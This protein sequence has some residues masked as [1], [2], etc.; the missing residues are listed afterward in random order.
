[1]KVATARASAGSLI[2]R[3]AVLLALLGLMFLVPAIVSDPS[4]RQVMPWF[5]MLMLLQ[6]AP[7]L[8]ARRQDLFAPPVIGGIRSL[9]ST[10]GT[11][12][13]F[14]LADE[15]R[16]DMLELTDP[17]AVAR[18][19][20]RAVV[21]SV[22]GLAAQYVGYYGRF[23]VT[24]AGAF[25]RVAGIRWSR[26]TL[27][28][29]CAGPALAFLISYTVF[30]LRVGV[31]L[32]DVTQLA[33]GK[34]VWRDNPDLSWMSRGV[35]IGFLPL[36]FFAAHRARDP[37]R[38]ALLA[39][40]LAALACGFLVTRLGQRGPFF[41]AL[42]AGIIIIHYLR[43][44]V[45]VWAFVL[46][47]LLG[48]TVSNLLIEYRVADPDEMPG[49]ASSVATNPVQ[50]L[51]AHENERQRFATLALVI[52]SFPDKVPYLAGESWLSLLVAP[53]PRWIWPEKNQFFP[54]QDNRIVYQLSGVPAP[55][56]FLG[57]LYANLSWIGVVVGMFMMGVF[58]RAL[59]EW[60][61]RHPG[62]P[63]VALLYGLILI[64]FEPTFL[65]LS[66]MLQY[67]FP[68]WLMIAALALLGRE[69]RGR[70]GHL[71]S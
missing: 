65:G 10:L 44:R 42:L 46:V 51:A 5:A 22:I 37:G 21:A 23:G 68:A 55:T 20:T 49:G 66:A 27:I 48:M 33:A 7:A 12:L 41:N 53:I 3:A 13:S 15:M 43:R 19:G 31:S 36:L 17:Q 50:I 26:R 64:T 29:V 4:L 30:Q 39:P 1:M 57:V 34:A 8:F 24:L 70:G 11:L 54:W 28:L 62:D 38:L 47:M 67:V 61:K 56:P 69:R 40:V 18:A 6:A 60:L 35:E 9:I 32:F 52:D 58:Y 59:Y 71:T 25:P 63:N 14:V 16:L 45:P 2:S